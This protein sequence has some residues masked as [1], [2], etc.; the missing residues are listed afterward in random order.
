MASAP[1]SDAA[2]RY[3]TPYRDERAPDEAPEAAPDRL[4][5]EVEDDDDGP[6]MVPADAFRYDDDADDSSS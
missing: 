4:H 1:P 5:V 2:T 6:E 3:S